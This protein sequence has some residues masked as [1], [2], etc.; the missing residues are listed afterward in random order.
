MLEKTLQGSKILSKWLVWIAGILIVCSAFLVTAEVLMR[1]LLNTSIAGAD[2]LTGYAFAIATS[3]AFASALHE[4]AHIR[5]DALILIVPRAF[6]IAANFVGI[7]L[8]VGFAGFVAWIAWFLVADTIDLWSR[9]ITPLRTPLAYPQVPWLIGWL[10]FVLTGILI[11]LSAFLRLLRK[12]ISGVEA[13]IG[14]KTIEE[15][16]DDESVT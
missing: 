3:L 16:I 1:K 9:S 11:I 7:V 4:R 13:L 2:E 10:F 15:Q 6:Q 14:A 5:V 12:N 8:L